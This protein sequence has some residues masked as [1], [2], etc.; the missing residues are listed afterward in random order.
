MTPLTAFSMGVETRLSTS[1]VERPGGFGLDFD[2]GRGE[3]RE[4]VEW[5]AANDVEAANH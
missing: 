3:L 2:E 4:D 5:G 1:V